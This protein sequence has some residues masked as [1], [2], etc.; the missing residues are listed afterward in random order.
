MEWKGGEI[1]VGDRRAAGEEGRVSDTGGHL[2]WLT[3]LM[4][5]PFTQKGHGDRIGGCVGMC[6]YATVE[7]GLYWTFWFYACKQHSL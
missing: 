4:L 1:S 3:A 2:P 6:D 7:I 5:K